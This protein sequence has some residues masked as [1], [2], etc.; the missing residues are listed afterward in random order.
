MHNATMGPAVAGVWST[1]ARART[2]TVDVGNE[3]PLERT[4]RVEVAE[5]QQNKK[6]YTIGDSQA[7]DY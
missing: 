1:L 7:V 4:R 6:Y 2:H 3:L 5:S